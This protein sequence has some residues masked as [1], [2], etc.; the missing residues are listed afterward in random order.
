MKLRPNLLL[1]TRLAER[2]I[3]RGFLSREDY[4]K[5]LAEL[6]DLVDVAETVVVEMTKVG[7][8]NVESTEDE[9]LI[10]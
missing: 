8:S 4:E 1:D 9:E 3:N 5:H 2:H 7:L 10:G 6:P